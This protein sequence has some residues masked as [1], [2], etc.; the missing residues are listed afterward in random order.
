[1]VTA[2]AIRQ[3]LRAG[4][5]VLAAGLAMV[6]VQLV[7]KYELV[8]QTYFRQDDFH[9]LIRGLRSGFTWDYLMWV[10][11]GHLLP[12][13]FGIS[14]AMARLGGYNE[15][16]AHTLTI[17]LQAGASLALLRLLWLLF[18]ARPAI[19]V[20][21]GLYLVTPMTIPSLSWWAAVL[22]TLPLQLALPMA[23]S[24]HVLYARDGRVRH[25]LAACGWIGFG[26]LFFVKA[27]FVP[28]LLFVITVGWLRPARRRLWPAWAL[29]AGILAAYSWVFFT[30]LY[31][32]VQLNDSTQTPR[33]PSAGVAG[34]F[35][36]ILATRALVPTAL[37]GPWE[38]RPIGDDYAMAATP[39]PAA[40]IALGVAAV[41]VG[42]SVL[43]RRRAW[44][45]WLVLLGYFLLADVVPVLLGRIELLGPG[46]LGYEL[47]YL[48][49]TA[50]VLAVV[51]G[52][53]F[54]PLDGEERPW[55]RRSRPPARLRWAWVPLAAV[56]TAGS[57]WSVA[58]YADRPLG[59][60]ARSYVL[61]AER[62]LAQV[63]EG[64]VVLDTYVPPAVAAPAFFHEYALHS[65]V[66]SVPAPRPVTWVWR[67]AG[68]VRDPLT[69][70]E[71]GRLRPVALRGLTI[72]QGASCV[73]VGG[74][75]VRFPLPAPLRGGDWTVQISYLNAAETT[76]SVRLGLGRAEVTAGRDLGR[77]FATI[78]GE[79]DH[80]AISAAGPGACVGEVRIGVPV[81]D[82]TGAAVPPQP[83]EG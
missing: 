50:M 57:V 38:W 48:A 9:Y 74:N 75:E 72:P 43:Y 83:V 42:V 54:I 60:T 34:E 52:L 66:L 67:L 17:A 15:A 20:P 40:W 76:L 37:G 12:G 25:L 80:L 65:S 10:D 82:D 46:V 2:A 53:A 61:T 16:L 62:A 79:G 64:T 51:V 78:G 49:A 55:S 6:A 5:A 32:S 3:R 29:Y 19:L 81:P 13:G 30:G 26:L 14:W 44:L 58:A 41:V 59:R 73:P 36:W 24:S 39:E 31:G 4:D 28:V 7:W 70:D 27:A 8:R 22:E 11:V 21:L 68:P 18:G 69:F 23:L 77:T 1:M 47:R 56:V 33:L 63:P 35:A 71:R 45:A